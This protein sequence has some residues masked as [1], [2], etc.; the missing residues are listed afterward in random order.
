[1]IDLSVERIG[2]SRARVRIHSNGGWAASV[3]HVH[4][5][6]LTTGLGETPAG[7]LLRLTDAPV[8]V[9]AGQAIAVEDADAPRAGAAYY[10]EDLRDEGVVWHGPAILPA[11][12]TWE[13]AT[14]TL[15]PAAPNPFKGATS[16]AF[17]LAESGQVDLSVLDLRGRTVATIVDTALPAGGHRTVWDGHDDSGAAAAQGVYLVRLSVGGRQATRTVAFAGR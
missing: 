2:D 14:V 13:P 17:T 4:R 8:I 15:S 3:L 6:T 7:T 16:I 10:L 11:V 1:V 12:A 5:T 9:P